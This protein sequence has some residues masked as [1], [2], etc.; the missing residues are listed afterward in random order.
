MPG[1]TLSLAAAAE[2]TRTGDLWVF[3]GHSAA[4]RAIRVGTNSPVNHV[5][6]A[7]VVEDL[8]R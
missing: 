5:G 1:S 4:D 7:V 6:M 3:R 2:L 8:P